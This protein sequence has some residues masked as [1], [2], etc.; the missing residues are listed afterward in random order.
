MTAVA[1]GNQDG[2]VALTDDHV[3]SP[4]RTGARGGAGETSRGGELN[5]EL[6]RTVVGIYRDAAGRGPTRAQAFFHG[7]VLVVLMEQVLTKVERALA[8]GGRPG[9]VHEMRD[10]L[11]DAMRAE[12]IAAAERLTGAKVSA[13]MVSNDVGSD[14]AAQVFILDRPM[15]N[16]RTA[17]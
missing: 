3:Q 7:N 14:M 10:A 17:G 8:E 16:P 1:G 4:D 6:A 11:Q 12:L 15:P 5:A 13:L 2:W 9:S